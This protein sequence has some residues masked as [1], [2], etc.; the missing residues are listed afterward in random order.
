MCTCIWTYLYINVYIYMCVYIYI[1]IYIWTNICK[2]GCIYICVYIYTYVY[3]YEHIYIYTHL[4][5]CICIYAYIFYTW[6]YIFTC[7]AL[8]VP[9]P[10]L[11]SW[12]LKIPPPCC[13]KQSSRPFHMQQTHLLGCSLLQCVASHEQHEVCPG[14]LRYSFDLPCMWRVCV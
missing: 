8:N 12:F 6:I 1:C 10:P 7:M 2:Y 3:V 14:V 5:V 9:H 4:Y 11:L 13:V